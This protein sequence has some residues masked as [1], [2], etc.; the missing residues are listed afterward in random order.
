M[1][2][3]GTSGPDRDGTD[4][5]VVVVG[6]G[7]AGL[8]AAVALGRSRRSVV[9]IDAGSPR[10][11]PAEGV[12]NLLT[13]DGIP[14]AELV[15]LGTAEVEQYGGS[16]RRGHAVAA[17]ALEPGFAV[18]LADGSTLTCRRLL[19]A[20]GARDQLPTVPGLAERWGRDVVHCPYCHG[21]EVRDQPIGVLGTSPMAMHQLLL[22]RQLS[23]D[24]VYLPH[25]APDLTDEQTAQLD[26]LGIAVAPAPA[27]RI[28]VED[29]RIVGVT[30][31][32]GT[33]VP[34]SVIAVA[35]TMDPTSPVLDSLGLRPEP[36]PGAPFAGSSY[37]SG[38][39]GSTSVPGLYLAGNIT[40]PMAQVVTAAG[41]G[42]MAGAV[43]NADMA[44]EDAGLAV[45]R[46]RAG[47]TPTAAAVAR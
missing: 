30:L 9:V 38:Q 13:R 32:D 33:T 8:A 28:V 46:L 44:A 26:A 43:A 22:F 27:A 40:E 3:D 14:P 34:R 21:W 37:P 20:A 19:V 16:V 29:D 6:G 31:T 2:S 1:S 47:A 10:N 41:Q 17:R 5:D 25:T 35:S 4:V 23:D 45:A 39:G 15:R 24:V 11:A 36:I 12:H 18:E 7:A 42:L